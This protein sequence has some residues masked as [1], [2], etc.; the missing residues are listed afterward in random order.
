M[1]WDWE[2]NT[3]I[4]KEMNKMDRKIKWLWESDHND[5][6]HY[7]IMLGVSSW[8]LIIIL[9]GAKLWNSI[10]FSILSFAW[11]MRMRYQYFNKG[12]K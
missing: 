3:W 12:G 7:L 1:S 6:W 5:K 8:G 11:F 2:T 9:E 4:I 10:A